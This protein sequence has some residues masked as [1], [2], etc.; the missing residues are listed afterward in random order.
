MRKQRKKMR[1]IRKKKES[2]NKE[3]NKIIT[4]KRTLF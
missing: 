3:G 4:L 2:N 1:N